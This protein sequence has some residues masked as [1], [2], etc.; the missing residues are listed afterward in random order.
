MKRIIFIF[1]ALTA[2]KSFAQKVELRIPIG[3][4]APIQALDLT[5][6]NK[7]LA[8]GG[9]DRGVKIWSVA[10]GRQL[11][12]LSLSNGA[13][14]QVKFISDNIH[15]SV[16]MEEGWEYWDAM[17]G[18]MLYQSLDDKDYLTPPLGFV[19]SSDGKKVA[20]T[21]KSTVEIKDA[22]NGRTLQ[23]FNWT[24]DDS[25]NYSF[26]YM[27][28]NDRWFVYC[29]EK[30]LIVYDLQAKKFLPV[31]I[32]IE[33]DLRGM[34][35]SKTKNELF[36]IGN[37]DIYKIDLNNGAL[38]LTKHNNS[39][40]YDCATSADGKYLIAGHKFFSTATLEEAFNVDAKGDDSK[41][42]ATDKYYITFDRRTGEGELFN[43]P[44]LSKLRDFTNETAWL[45][46]MLVD[47][48]NN[49]LIFTTDQKE[50]RIWDLKSYRFTQTVRLD[51][52][53]V[54]GKPNTFDSYFTKGGNYLEGSYSDGVVVNYHTGKTLHIPSKRI[55]ALSPDGTVGFSED[56]GNGSI[57]ELAGGKE[58]KS[59]DIKYPR[60]FASPDNK[61]V[62]YHVY[63]YEEVH[64]Y[65]YRKA[66][67]TVANIPVGEYPVFNETGS[68]FYSLDALYNHYTDPLH[69]ITTE[70]PSGRRL[71]SILLKNLDKMSGSHFAISKDEKYVAVLYNPVDEYYMVKGNVLI[72]YDISNGQEIS[73]SINVDGADDVQF[74][75]NNLLVVLSR[76]SNTVNIYDALS[77]TH[78]LDITHFKGTNDWIAVTPAGFYD[79]NMQSLKKFYFVKGNEFVDPD[80]YF[81]KFYTPN[82]FARI[83]NG[84]LFKADDAINKV[85]VVKMTYATVQRNLS[86]ED[87]VPGYQNTT[88]LA[89]ITVKAIAPDDAV[90]E[91]RLFHN[92]KI[93]TL[94]TRNL[95]VADDN[96]SSAVTK[97]YNV[98][99]LPGINTFRSVALNSQR[100]ES[101]PDLFTVDYKQP[102]SSG[103]IK[104][105]NNND[106][107]GPVADIDKNATLHLVVVGINEYQ[108]KSMRLNYAMADATAFKT[109]LEQ[110]AKSVISNIK[111]YFVT[112]D[113][114]DK[115]GIITAL[116]EVQQNAKA[117]DVFIFYYAGHGVIG[118]DKEFYL[119]PSDVSDLK[120]VQAELE[121]KGIA[122]KLLQQYAIDIP[123]QKQLFILDACQSAGAFETMMTADANQ[124]KSISLVARSTGTHWMAASG[125]QQFANE[126][127]SLGH[128]A[129]T[130][131]LLQALK[132]EAVNNKMIT[133]NG[134]KNFLQ[135]QVPALMKKYNG[136][137]QYPASYGFGNDF[138]VEI[139]IK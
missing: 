81:E 119:V 87:D 105:I 113:K 45:Q 3:H 18:K 12:T 2:I 31:K 26:G 89:E 68:R 59:I 32:N 93:V 53:N 128:G 56:A 4:T 80:L 34:E 21:N 22:A 70:M 90:D 30:Q 64:I 77:G 38:L 134:L 107:N 86:V 109:E 130:Y 114:A 97:K 46:Q 79:G 133:V 11:R 116:K 19:L 124:Q 9:A 129:F 72:V 55:R 27:A 52:G 127:S 57:I 102:G 88:G 54:I 28:L 108:N 75:N 61:T 131:V 111:T 94:T 123:A 78:L 25:K 10:D 71:G 137:A 29:Q 100:T 35:L 132:G 50:A 82:L 44:A 92:G 101:K 121:Q 63:P 99:L 36:V 122:A 16:R 117:N 98:N 110:D 1:L 51:T 91:I 139:T 96:K 106:V 83:M 40:T 17:E 115:A 138:P 67:E 43:L 104:P 41:S 85:P 5:A 136:S 42:I 39:F 48:K 15:L 47:N 125:A 118:K 6:D 23:N 69:L 20:V 65:D 112:D 95:I 73:R 103:D 135:L 33:K 7:Y 14:Y 8:T 74:I 126:F 66:V 62:L 24:P 76:L 13:W 58:I 49:E 84:E 60:F 120:N 37:A